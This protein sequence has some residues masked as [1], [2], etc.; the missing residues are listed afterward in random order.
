MTRTHTHTHTQYA[1]DSSGYSEDE[2]K[3]KTKKKKK[4]KGKKD[5]KEKEEEE[6]EKKEK[7]DKKAEKEKKEEEKRRQEAMESGNWKRSGMHFIHTTPKPE[8]DLGIWEKNGEGKREVTPDSTLTAFEIAREAAAPMCGIAH[9]EKK[10]SSEAM[11]PRL[12]N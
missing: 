5:K 9:P 7:K 2:D 10:L 12:E 1:S 6:E 8:E 3:E 4:K 11:P